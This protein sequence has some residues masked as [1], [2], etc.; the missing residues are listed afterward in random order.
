MVCSLT[1]F[2][3]KLGISRQ[4][5][6]QLIEQQILPAIAIGGIWFIDP[7]DLKLAEKRDKKPGPKPKEK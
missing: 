5:V 7:A 3:E 6:Q 2:S 4:R 1:F